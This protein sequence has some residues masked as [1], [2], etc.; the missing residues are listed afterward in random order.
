MSDLQLAPAPGVA[1]ELRPADFRRVA[2]LTREIAGINLPPGKEGL[3]RARLAKRLRALGLA[4]FDDYL[5]HVEH[6]ASRAELREM[7]DALTTNK[8]SFFREAQHFAYLR[9]T[10]LP[11]HAEA[12]RP[13]RI[14]SAGCST[15]EEPYT[16][17]MTLREA[18]PEPLAAAARVLATD[19]SARVLARA[20]EATYPAEMAAEV[21]APLRARHFAAT[22]DGQH[23]VVDR[24]RRLV[25][26]AR[27]NLMRPWPMR[28]PFDAIFCRNVMIYFD[29]P[30]QAALV[31]RFW[32]LL[33]P[34]GHLFV[35]HA[36]SLTGRSHGFG[37]VR[38]AVYVK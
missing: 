3:V 5:A 30:T 17:A 20:R 12:G 1:P 18:L 11:R 37:Y 31:E 23:R 2:Q 32:Q 33:G 26:F 34:G 6:E 14:W 27:L 8:T 38:P 4:S 21:P 35:G 16:L 28:G 9:E 29:K 10:L 22:P 36:E 15:G 24:T 25:R 7:I 19:I 13:P